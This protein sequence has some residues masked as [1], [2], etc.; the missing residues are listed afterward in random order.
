MSEVAS[1]GDDKLAAHGLGAYIAQATDKGD[2]HQIV[3]GVVVMSLFVVLCN[4]FFWRPI[5]AYT[6]RRATLS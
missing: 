5:Y 1:W 6:S 4:R 2:F 3:L